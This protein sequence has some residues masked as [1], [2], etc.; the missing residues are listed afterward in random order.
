M[1][2][3]LTK[4]MVLGC[5]FLVVFTQTAYAYIDPGTG[6]MVF[7]LLIAGILGGFYIVKIYFKRIVIFFKNLLAKAKNARRK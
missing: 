6:N 1:N 5:V 2:S 3:N 4:S 7:Q